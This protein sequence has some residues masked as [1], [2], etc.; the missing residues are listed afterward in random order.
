M[1]GL[2][3]HTPRQTCPLECDRDSGRRPLV[4]DLPP[5]NPDATTA[6][7]SRQPE[8]EACLSQGLG[9]S[10]HWLYLW[11]DDPHSLCYVSGSLGARGKLQ[12]A[13]W[14]QCGCAVPSIKVC[15]GS[16]PGHT[17]LHCCSATQ[18]AKANRRPATSTSHGIPLHALPTHGCHPPMFRTL[19]LS[20][21]YYANLVQGALKSLPYRFSEFRQHAISAVQKQLH[22]AFISQCL[23]YMR[24]QPRPF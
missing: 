4:Q 22:F 12:P 1:C 19:P 16:P 17:C 23:I 3:T 15:S 24:H 13:Q 8:A 20:L 2:C 11:E 9:L 14:R 10:S 5:P 6:G 21:S 18:E 7:S